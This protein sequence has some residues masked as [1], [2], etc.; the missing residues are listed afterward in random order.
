ME[1][2]KLGYLPF[3]VKEIANFF[4]VN[5][6]VR[7]LNLESQIFIFPFRDLL[8]DGQA[9]LWYQTQLVQ[10]AHHC[11]WFTGSWQIYEVF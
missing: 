3:G 8:E 6:H 11:V 5:L 4:I 7:N 9:Q 1:L 2:V 10:A